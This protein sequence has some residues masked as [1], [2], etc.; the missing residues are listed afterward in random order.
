[1]RN[2]VF[3]SK[4]IVNQDLLDALEFLQ[5]DNNVVIS[6]VSKGL[7]D[8]SRLICDYRGALS[9]TDKEILQYMDYLNS[10]IYYIEQ[11]KK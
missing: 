9:F 2:E 1:M 8:I 3:Y 11:M 7:S 4:A 10:A 6:D 5:E